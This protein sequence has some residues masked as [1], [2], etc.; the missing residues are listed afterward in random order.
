MDMEIAHPLRRRLD[1][2]PL[3]VRE[4]FVCCLK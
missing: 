4:G 3:I 1:V 2:R